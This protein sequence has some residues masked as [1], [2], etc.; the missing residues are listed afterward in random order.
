[1]TSM[2]QNYTEVAKAYCSAQEQDIEESGCC[3]FSKSSSD[4]RSFVMCIFLV[5]GLAIAIA[6]II[7]WLI[8]LFQT[9]K[10]RKLD[11]PAR[12]EAMHRFFESRVDGENRKRSVQLRPLRE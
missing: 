9:R 4:V 10:I 6:M 1:M 12:V 8:I 5:L 11:G 2:L 7:D 3:F